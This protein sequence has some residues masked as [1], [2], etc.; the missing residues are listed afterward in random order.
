MREVLVFYICLF[1][2]ACGGANVNRDLCVG[3]A[4]IEYHDAITVC[5]KEKLT[6]DQCVE[7]YDIE[8]S[9][10]EKQKGCR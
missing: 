7:K 9:F 3:G 4:A 5:E 1:L 2:G 10:E 6:Y 8:N